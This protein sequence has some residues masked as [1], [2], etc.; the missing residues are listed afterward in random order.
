MGAADELRADGGM[1]VY[2]W[3][4]KIVSWP[5]PAGASVTAGPP[6]SVTTDVVAPPFTVPTSA[7]TTRNGRG[8]TFGDLKGLK[9]L[10]FP[11]L[12]MMGLAFCLVG[13]V[14]PLDAK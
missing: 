12:V 14:D 11:V 13:W 7:H 3:P 8:P 4:A 1:T 9:M 5:S 10:V 6:N 2:V